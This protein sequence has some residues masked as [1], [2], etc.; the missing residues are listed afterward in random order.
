MGRHLGGE[1]IDHDLDVDTLGGGDLG[2]G[3]TRVERGMELSVGHAEDLREDLGPTGPTGAALARSV[4]ATG[5]VVATGATGRTGVVHHVSDV[6]PEIGQLLI[7]LRL[8]D[9]TG[10]DLVGDV[11]LHVG[12]ERIDHDLDVDALG[13]SHLGE[14][15]TRLEGGVELVG[16][17]AECGGDGI[18]AG[19]AGATTTHL[20]SAGT[21]TTRGSG[22]GAGGRRRG[23]GGGVVGG[24]G[25]GD[26]RHGEHEAA[27]ATGGEAGG[28]SD[29]GELLVHGF[30]LGDSG[31]GGVTSRERSVRSGCAHRVPRT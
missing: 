20:V 24:L 14:G 25:V 2:D 8:R 10:G 7:G 29:G 5:A 26:R 6:R 22:E 23:G 13:G 17:H 31:C 1:R 28:E 4:I 3:L 15:L 30:L 18:H 11:R 16:G 27:D 9:L 12:G 19:A 21:L